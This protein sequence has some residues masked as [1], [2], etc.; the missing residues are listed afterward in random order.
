MQSFILILLL[1]SLCLCKDSNTNSD[2][3]NQQSHSSPNTI[4]PRN[5][6]R[7]SIDCATDGKSFYSEKS[8]PSKNDKKSIETKPV[9]ENKQMNEDS[10]LLQVRN[11]VIFTSIEL[12]VGF[13]CLA[14]LGMTIKGVKSIFH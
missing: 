11:S 12:M 14:L 7:N 2:N 13:S 9:R 3:S 1:A 6:R 8:V 5:T 10:F 4:L